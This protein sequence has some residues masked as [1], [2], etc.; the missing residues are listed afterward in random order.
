MSSLP[1]KMG[2]ADITTNI[3][4]EGLRILNYYQNKKFEPFVKDTTQEYVEEERIKILLTDYINWLSTTDIHK[5]FDGDLQ[6]NNT[7]K[8]NAST[9]KNDI[10]KVILMLK[11][12]FAKHCAQEEPEWTTRII[13]EEFENKCRREQGRV[14]VGVSE[15]TKRRIYNKALPWINEIDDNWMYK[16]NL[17][18]E[19]LNLMNT[20]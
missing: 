6:S 8:L 16:I 15:D 1:K 3:G 14:N 9:L 5:Y 2:E 13:G 18:Q 17:G 7:F 19:N 11:D 12:K 20:A 10:R 4:N